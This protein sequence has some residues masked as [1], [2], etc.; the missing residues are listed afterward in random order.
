M[1]YALAAAVLWGVL[2]GLFHAPFWPVA[3]GGLAAA[4]LAIWFE[5]EA[6]GGR[7]TP[8]RANFHLLLAAA[9]VFLAIFGVGVVSLGYFLGEWLLHKL[10]RL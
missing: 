5:W 9:Y 3:I 2:C 7:A 10:P 8:R 6:L 1:L 4:G